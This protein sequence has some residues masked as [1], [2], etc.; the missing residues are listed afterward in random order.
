MEKGMK[1]VLI[2]MF[3]S[4]IP[5]LIIFSLIADQRE[6]DEKNFERIY[7]SSKILTIKNIVQNNHNSK[8]I[9]KFSSSGEVSGLTANYKHL[10][11]LSKKQVVDLIINNVEY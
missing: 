8:I 10:L 7:F 5:L 2:L 4:Y 9:D 1:V 6:A 11:K 3:L